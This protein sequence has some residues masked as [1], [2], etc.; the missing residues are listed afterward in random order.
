[1]TTCKRWLLLVDAELQ[2]L[3]LQPNEVDYDY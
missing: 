1:V 2:R 3:G